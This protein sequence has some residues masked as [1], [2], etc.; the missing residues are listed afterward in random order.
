MVVTS[1]LQLVG[2]ELARLRQFVDDDADG[3]SGVVIRG[4]AGIGK[5]TLW[6]NAVDAAGQSGA[7]VLL[8]RCAEAE[9]PLA[10][11]GLADLLEGCL[12]RG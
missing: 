1:G 8:T 6:R 4:D 10:L 2:Q 7:S 5:T 3:A 11:G 12:L 9:M